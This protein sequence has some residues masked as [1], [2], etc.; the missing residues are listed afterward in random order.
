MS[1]I[2]LYPSELGLSDYSTFILLWVVGTAISVIIYVRCIMHVTYQMSITFN[3][4]PEDDLVRLRFDLAQYVNGV[5]LN[6][7]QED[8]EVDIERVR[9]LARRRSPRR[10]G[11]AQN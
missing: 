10:H 8:R 1:S 4:E 11:V 7:S 5:L 9:L 6:Q 3:Y 2:P